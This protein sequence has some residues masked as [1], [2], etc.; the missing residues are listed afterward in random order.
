MAAAMAEEQD[1]V[2]KV[3]VFAIKYSSYHRRHLLWHKAAET[4]N[5][6][7]VRH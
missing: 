4:Y 5:I 7:Y 1:M 2:R 6:Q 3:N